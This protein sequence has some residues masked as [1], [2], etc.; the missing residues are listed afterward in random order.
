M[1]DGDWSSDVCS[2]DLE[3]EAAAPELAACAAALVDEGCEYVLV[4]GAHEQG[5]QVVNTLYNDRGEVNRRWWDRLPG[6]Y[7]GS[8]CTLASA[9]AAFLALGHDVPEAVEEAQAY[10]WQTL[11]T[12]FR[13]GM[14]QSIPDRLYWVHGDDE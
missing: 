6:S 5:V 11:K 14:G 7:H 8:G 10:T 2:S 1:L 13:P 4:T 12:A 9:V 3:E